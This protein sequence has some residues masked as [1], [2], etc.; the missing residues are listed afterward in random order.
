MMD[1][2]L[3]SILHCPECKGDLAFAPPH[4]DSTELAAGHALFCTNGHSYPI[5]G[6]IPRF[7]PDEQ[8]AGNFGFEWNL[9]NRTQLDQRPETRDQR[10]EA[11]DEEHE[12]PI[13]DHASDKVVDYSGPAREGHESEDTF[14]YKTGLQPEE[15]KGKRVLDAGCGTGRFAAVAAAAGAEVVACD[16]SQAVEA[17]HQNLGHLPNVQVIQADIF[18]LPF[19]PESFDLI[20][21]LGVLH[22][23]PDTRQAFLSLPP[24]L[25]PGGKLCAWVYYRQPWRGGV[26][27]PYHLMSDFLRRWTIHWPRERL[28]NFCRLRARYHL[29][30]RLPFLGRLFLRLWPGSIHPDYEWRV[31]DTFDWYSPIYQWKHTWEEV[32]GWFKEAGLS[33]VTRLPFPVSGWGVMRSPASQKQTDA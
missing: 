9:F 11:K 30:V 21:S 19:A 4:S 8:Y 17:C 33:E 3:L 28:L 15:L 24:L 16:L 26:I 2:D 25:K 13:T 7:V 29:L 12:S 1:P 14:Y 6:G 27:P 10:P 5:V 31:L 22:H 18:K 23:T 20:Y 32:E